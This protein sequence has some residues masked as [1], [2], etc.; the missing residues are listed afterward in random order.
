MRQ[1]IIVPTHLK[2]A[3]SSWVSRTA[4]A[5]S[6]LVLGMVLFMPAA[7]AEAA[8]YLEQSNY[9][10]YNANN[11][12]ATV[13]LG[14][15]PT[16]D[17]LLIAAVGF[18]GQSGTGITMT[19]AGWTQVGSTIIN[20][21][22]DNTP[23]AAQAVFYKFAG[24]AESS[25]VTAALAGTNTSSFIHVYEFSAD[26]DF[27]Y[28]TYSTQ[29]N[30]SGSDTDMNGTTGAV[31]APTGDELLFAAFSNADVTAYSGLAP[32]GFSG[33][34]D[35][36]TGSSGS[37]SSFFSAWSFD[38]TPASTTATVT[39]DG[40]SG[41][42]Q[43]WIGHL[44]AFD[45]APPVDTTA[46]VLTEVTPVS[47][48]SDRTPDYNFNTDE[49]GTITYGGDCTSAT[50]S[51]IVGDNTVT[52]DELSRGYHDN[53]TI[54]V[55]D[56]STNVSNMLTLAQFRIL[57][58]S[59]SASNSPA[60]TV[61]LFDPNGGQTFN[62]G[63]SHTIVWSS[64]GSGVSGARVSFSANGGGSWTV[65]EDNLVASSI[66]WTVPNISTANGLIR[67]ELLG[68]STVLT[69]DQSDMPFTVVG[70]G[71]VS[72][73]DFVG[74]PDST[75]GADDTEGDDSDDASS[76]SE[77][78]GTSSN[79]AMN[80]DVA[81]SGYPTG[82]MADMLV[83]LADDNNRATDADATVYYLGL[84]GKRHPFLSSQAFLTWYA[85]FSQVVAIE[86]SALEQI[87]LGAPVLVRPGTKWVKISTDEKTYFVEPGNVLRWVADEE[88]AM[89]LGGE[90]WNQN[91]IDVDVSMFTQFTA[92]TPITAEELNAGWPAGSLVLNADGTQTYYVSTTGM[93]RPFVSD[94]AFTDNNFQPSHVCTTPSAA[95][96]LSLP[97]GTAI[98][99]HE[100]TLFSLMH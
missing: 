43:R 79:G 52:F 82:V 90:N 20:T 100:D 4:G 60:A 18:R 37:P 68:S 35:V 70:D 12:T 42:W 58:G 59:S 17:N 91:I 13:N 11:A 31:V 28:R 7:P 88:V 10:I 48:S 38:D 53:C 25:T 66:G 75:E 45:I 97:L 96:W 6:G 5:M 1:R 54:T 67:V 34:H 93:R 46:P 98:V 3:P 24:A 40:T 86:P 63:D 44:M 92:G 21:L 76:L 8:A 56:A 85:D 2:P 14:A 41:N 95:G 49:A 9:S 94:V 64:G 55:T 99:G 39:I 65:I 81:N 61:A 77:R 87:P 83:K 57:G 16:E 23:T 27:T 62:H 78:G 50:T 32:A 47:D 69:S 15:A 72:E 51:A 29:N 80:R 74:T 89:M 73:Q 33:V 19:S 84:D 22:P 30:A 36:D 71:T 26:G